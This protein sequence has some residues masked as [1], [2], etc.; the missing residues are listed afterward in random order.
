M[1]K[2]SS[3]FIGLKP[4]YF[5]NRPAATLRH[6]HTSFSLHFHV[7][8][9][10]PFRQ[11]FP[12]DVL[13]EKLPGGNR[14]AAMRIGRFPHNDRAAVAE[15][16]LQEPA[17]ICADIEAPRQQP[18]LHPDWPLEK[19][20]TAILIAAVTA[21]QLVTER[22]AASGP[23]LSDICDPDDQPALKV[24]CRKLEGGNSSVLPC[25]IVRLLCCNK[26]DQKSRIKSGQVQVRTKSR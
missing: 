1:R 19:L 18:D 20:A 23:S 8:S 7:Y 10:S 16:L 5:P 6:S 11:T 3:W 22:D 4:V 9:D 25:S 24:V 21:V 26:Y 2:R 13:I 14:A 17:R 12:W 15:M